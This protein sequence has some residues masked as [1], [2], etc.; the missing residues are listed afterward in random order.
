MNI[1][2]AYMPNGTIMGDFQE[3]DNGSQIPTWEVFDPVFVSPGNN[4][5]QLFP[6]LAITE[7]KSVIVRQDEINFG[8]L[9]TPARELRNHYSSQFGSGIQ[10]TV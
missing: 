3:L 10:L 2:I 9:Y 4:Q 8:R 7:E 1:K 5:I 6:F